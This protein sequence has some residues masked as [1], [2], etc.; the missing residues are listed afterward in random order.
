MLTKRTLS[1]HNFKLDNLKAALAGIKTFFL[2]TIFLSL[3]FSNNSCIKYQ[4]RLLSPEKNLNTLEERR[5]DSPELAN[6]LQVNKEVSSWPPLT[7]DL[8]S[9]TL[10]AFYYNPELDIARAKW[11]VAK[12]GQITAGEI[13]NP[14]LNP[15][16]GYNSTTPISLMPPW[17]PEVA[18]DIPVE[19]AKKRGLRLIEARQL[20]QA[21]RW[22]LLSAAWSVRYELRQALVE[23]YAASSRKKILQEKLQLLDEL[24]KLSEIKKESGEI[25]GYE[26]S[27]VKAALN[28]TKLEAIEA[29]RAHQ[30]A[31]SRLASV[32]GV[33]VKALEGI[34]ISFDELEKFNFEIPPAEVRR[35]VLTRRT[36]ILSA[37]SEYAASEAALR[38]E[39]AKQYP[40]LHFG[41]TYQLDQTD[42][43]WTIGIALEL[44]IFG[45][46]RGPIAEAEA[47]RQ[48]KAAEFLSLQSKVLT[49]LEVAIQE[50]QAAQEKVQAAE[51]LLDNLRNQK[52]MAENQWRLGEISRPDLLTIELELQNTALLRLES[53]IEAQRA[54]SHLENILQSPLEVKDWIFTL[55]RPSDDLTSKKGNNHEKKAK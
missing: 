13:P 45:H 25:S 8:K 5:L 41:P 14:V 31:R 23:L 9:L 16:L 11:A 10:V 1:F 43:K 52:E 38:L 49:D 34:S 54:L 37:L 47:R 24:E 29:V 32:V 3:I 40:D 22:N 46:N 33:P 21:S 36:D 53:L 42:N 30:E 44:P 7:W 17:I 50:C 6:F 2:L 18:L 48:E 35:R 28:F 15:K 51:R 39:I 4:P 20:A 27:Q 12:A 55:N 26:L 19:V